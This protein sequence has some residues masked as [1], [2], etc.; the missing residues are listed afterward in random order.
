M[1]KR[2]D[3]GAWSNYRQQ[4]GQQKLGELQSL[5]QVNEDCSC[6]IQRVGGIHYIVERSV[7]SH[8][9][10]QYT[11]EYFYDVVINDNILSLLYYQ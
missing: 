11:P 6:A 10:R 8:C 1:L 7:T 5:Q 4:R 2:S 3:S 9:I